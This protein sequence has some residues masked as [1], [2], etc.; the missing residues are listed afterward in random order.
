M[1]IV[2]RRKQPDKTGKQVIMKQRRDEM[3][4]IDERALVYMA[5]LFVC[6][7]V[8]VF[9]GPARAAA[10]FGFVTASV[11]GAYWLGRSLPGRYV[12][13]SQPGSGMEGE[14]RYAS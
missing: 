12:T 9:A 6:S 10:T 14:E 4:V 8:A 7:A 11:E 2:C 3:D 13:P 5:V 1:T